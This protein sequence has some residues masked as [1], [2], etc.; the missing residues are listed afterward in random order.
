MKFRIAPAKRYSHELRGRAKDFTSIYN[1]SEQKSPCQQ[2]R[3]PRRGQ[4]R[5]QDLLQQQHQDTTIVSAPATLEPQS[6]TG[7]PAAPHQDQPPQLPQHLTAAQS[8]CKPIMATTCSS[9][10]G[11]PLP[12]RTAPSLTNIVLQSNHC[13]NLLWEEI[14]L[15]LSNSVLTFLLQLS[16]ALPRPVPSADQEQQPRSQAGPKHALAPSFLRVTSLPKVLFSPSCAAPHCYFGSSPGSWQVQR[17]KALT[18]TPATAPVPRQE[19]GVQSAGNS[20]P[21]R[22]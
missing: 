11:L 8:Q 4:G 7:S 6:T 1:Y 9:A 15:P 16:P 18:Q 2:Q 12:A 19:A 10:L 13:W 5:A 22:C 3:S 21:P 14:R 17:L 20:A